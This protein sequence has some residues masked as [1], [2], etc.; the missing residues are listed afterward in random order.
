MAQVG[1]LTA[2]Q[3]NQLNM[4]KVQQIMS[5]GTKRTEDLSE[6]DLRKV[7]ENNMGVFS[8]GQ[9]V[10]GLKWLTDLGGATLNQLRRLS[11][12]LD[13][14]MVTAQ[15]AQSPSADHASLNNS[16]DA[17][18]QNFIDVVNE[19]YK[20]NQLLSGSTTNTSTFTARNSGDAVSAFKT[21]AI[22]A[23]TFIG[24]D[25]AGFTTKIV[26]ADVGNNDT[27]TIGFS[28][29]ENAE[30]TAKTAENYDPSHNNEFKIGANNEETAR[31]FIQAW[32]RSTSTLTK[33]FTININGA[34]RVDLV[35]NSQ[36]AKAK[37]DGVDTP[38]Q[39]TAVG[40]QGGRIT[41]ALDNGNGAQS[42]ITL[43]GVRGDEDFL[44]KPGNFSLVEYTKGKVDAQAAVA[45]LSLQ[46]KARMGFE[47][48]GTND[49]DECAVYEYITPKG[50]V[51]RGFLTSNNDAAI[52]DNAIVFTTY[53]NATYDN[54]V[55]FT[56]NFANNAT[57]LSSG[58]KIDTPANATKLAA[59][60]NTEI[61]GKFIFQQTR[62]AVLPEGKPIYDSLGTELGTSELSLALQSEN[63][64]DVKFTDIELQKVGLDVTVKVHTTEKNDKGETVN[65]IYT[66]GAVAV[67]TDFKKGS[68]IEL[69]ANVVGGIVRKMYLNTGSNLDVTTNGNVIKVQDALRNTLRGGQLKAPGTNS[70]LQVE[71]FKFDTVF[72]SPKDFNLNNVTEATRAV[73]KIQAALKKV[74]NVEIG[75]TR[76]LKDYKGAEMSIT[77]SRDQFQ[78]HNESIFKIDAQGEYS[79]LIRLA[80]ISQLINAVI[81]NDMSS[82]KRA[83]EGIIQ[84]LRG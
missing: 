41:P 65:V 19:T 54:D 75:V 57:G 49:N 6:S 17:L 30:F 68:Q 37:A 11:G 21:G 69:T 74:N 39:V 58:N 34:D 82:V 72:G 7:F 40:S 79:E 43:L 31:N 27:C 38:F 78:E 55:A 16:F 15:D 32:N 29:G 76:A 33:E 45:P 80:E 2:G 73:A 18:K 56:V 4:E 84:G 67:N 23:N 59:N 22:T 71:S 13:Q 24:V 77:T 83:I 9:A 10:K 50:T 48:T 64:K 60:L 35:T 47:P 51:Y 46:F 5:K 3:L 44:G 12:I 52:S 28:N 14:M 62:Q 1:L 53:K 26:F 36:I 70:T 8:S 25:G 81:F 20:E 63:F 61:G 66:S 42:A